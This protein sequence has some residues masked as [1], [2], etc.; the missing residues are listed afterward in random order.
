MSV[1]AASNFVCNLQAFPAMPAVFNP[2]RDVDPVHDLGARS[3]EIRSIQLERYLAERT[4]K[5]RVLL[6]A[7]ALGYRGGHFSGIAMTSER[8]LLGNMCDQGIAADDVILGGGARTSSISRRI[9]A[10]GSTEST[11]TVV[12]GALKSAGIDTREVVLWNS[13]AAHPMRGAG[14]WLTNRKPSDP[15][16]LAARP[17]LEQFLALFPGT[18]TLA[19][20]NVAKDILDAM[21]L[22]VAAKLRHPANGGAM[23]FRAGLTMALESLGG[24]KH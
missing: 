23:E 16:L 15:E 11:A 5:A 10:A 4:G 24:S 17:L 3:P 21:G 12:W 2:W 20:G 14:M 19:V 1:S 6:I 18:Q 13:F 22:P 7:E 9:P 8:M